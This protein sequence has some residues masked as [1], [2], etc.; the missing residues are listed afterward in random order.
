MSPAEKLAKKLK[1]KPIPSEPTSPMRCEIRSLRQ[2]LGLTGNQAADGAGI[3]R[4]A[5]SRIERGY[6]PH[7]STAKKLSAFFGKP[8]EELWP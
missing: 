6:D 1:V 2:G 4:A 8:I 7:L 3:S 5:L